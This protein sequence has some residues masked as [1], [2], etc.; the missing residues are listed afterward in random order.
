MCAILK[1]FL[2]QEIQ[3]YESPIELENFMLIHGESIVYSV[4]AEM[5]RIEKALTVKRIV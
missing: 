4:G 5:D 1:V 2:I 3:S